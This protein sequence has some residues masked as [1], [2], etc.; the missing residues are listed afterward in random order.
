VTRTPAARHTRARDCI[1]ALRSGSRRATRRFLAAILPLLLLGGELPAQYLTRPELEWRAMHTAHFDVYFPADM[2]EWAEPVAR[3]LDGIADAVNALVGHTPDSRV[4][5]LIEDPSSISNG[6][7]LP[8]IGRPF[9]FLWPTPP[10]PSPTF[11]AYADWGEM[12]AVH[13][14]GHIAHLTIPSRNPRESRLW[15][16][17]PVHVGPLARRAPA[18]VVEGYATFVEGRITGNGRPHSTG[19][20]AVIRQFALEGRLPTYAQLDG[21]AAWLGGNMRYLVGSAFLEWLV[22]RKGDESLAH[23]WRRMSARIPRSFAAAFTGVYGAPPGELYGRFFAEAT[24]RAVEL[25]RELRASGAGLSEGALV[26]RMSWSTGDIAVSDDGE[27][28]ATV[29]RYAVRPSRVVVW[30]AR[31]TPDTAAARQRRQQLQRDSLDVPAVD[32]FPPARRAIATLEARG[33]RAFDAPRFL[34]DGRRLL[35]T[36]DEPLGDGTTRPDLFVWDMQRNDLRRVTHGAGIRA[37]DPSP[38][39]T[40]AIAA[41]CLNGICDLV[42]VDLERGAT[43]VIAHGSPGRVWHRPRWS[44]DGRRIAAGLHAEGRWNVVVVDPANGRITPA[45]PSDDK[46]RYQPA[47][48]DDSTLVITSEASGTANLA[49]VRLPSQAEVPLTQVTG[50]AFAADVHAASG[51]I[52]FLSLHARGLDVRRVSRDSVLGAAPFVFEPE[53]SPVTPRPLVAVDSFP[54]SR[55]VAVESYGLGPRPW[56][57]LPGATAGPDGAMLSL[58]AANI[59]PV[60]RLGV[61]AQAGYGERGTWRG[62]SIAATWRGWPVHV[63]GTLFSVSNEPSRQHGVPFAPPSLDATLTGAMVVAHHNHDAFSASWFTRVGG[64]AMRF[65]E[66]LSSSHAWRTQGFV[67]GGGSWSTGSSRRY[68]SIGARANATLGS[69][70]STT[71][72]RGVATATVLG[73]A[74]GQTLRLDGTWGLVDG[75]GAGATGRLDSHGTPRFELFA[76]GGSAQPFT[77]P[78]LLTQRIPLA[79]VPVGIVHGRTLQ[80]YRAETAVGMIRPYATWVTTGSAPGMPRFK[81]I[82]GAELRTNLP[83]YSIARLP[84]VQLL[85][86]MGY[87]VDEPYRRRTRLYASIVWRP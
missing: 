39:G 18:W 75:N 74:F 64:A 22:A 30:R 26:Q 21:S 78:A 80:L 86:G 12:L 60:G 72:S 37:A 51:R 68:M 81:R 67:G 10:S 83:S 8:F 44:P 16:L 29:V 84:A 85:A 53:P 59:D 33:F 73:H 6:F 56:I 76:V 54:V 36:H 58:M 50:A 7:A 9:V 4:T 14:Y 45:L 61:L 25:E 32:S 71:W 27:Y 1:A 79:A 42:V 20:A 49:I 55:D 34:P 43:R 47:W 87:S 69:T 63:S 70:M 15:S 17:L 5:V 57:V 19:R 40:S 62:G 41:R 48:A 23:L 35:V 13:E 28:L 24:A 46:S 2:R 31:E 38:D 77:D 66:G 3:R 65:D 52:W 82:Y 11:G